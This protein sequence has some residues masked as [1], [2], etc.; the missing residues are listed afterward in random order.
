MRSWL[1]STIGLLVTLLVL[2]VCLAFFAIRMATRSHP[3]P[4]RT[5]STYTADTAAVYRNAFGI[6]HIVASTAEDAVTVQGY[7]HAQDRLWQM[8]LYRR[9]GRGRLAEIIGNEAVSVDVFMRTLG[10]AGIA[11]Q[12]L[13]QSS[14]T[15]RT[16]LQAYARGVNAYIQDQ[17]DDIAFEFDALDYSPEPWTPEDCLIVGRMIAFELSLAF[18]SDIAY[19][20]I[21]AQRTLPIAR[22]YIP[23]GR[24]GEPTVVDTTKTRPVPTAQPSPTATTP[25]SPAASAYAL[26]PQSMQAL[27]AAFRSVRQALNIQA[28]GIGSNAWA[29]SRGP[30]KGALLANDPHMS[31]GM[32]SKFYQI[33][34]ATPTL[35]VVGMSVPGMPLVVSG[36]NDGVAWGVTNVMQDDVDFFLER[37]DKNPNYYVGTNGQRTKFRFQRDTIR[38]KG[39]ADTLI[40]IRYTTRSA[41]ISDAHLFRDPSVLFTAPRERATTL[42]TTSCLTYRWTASSASDEVLTLY[43]LATARSLA[44]VQRAVTTWRAPA[45]NLTVA[46]Q[47]GQVATIPMGVAPRRVQTDPHFLNPGWDAAFDWQGTVPLTTAGTLVAQRGFAVAANNTLSATP[48]P[49]IGT[50]YE[51]S[52]R[53]ERIH[54]LLDMYV[55]YTVRDAQL[56]QQD[57]VSPYAQHLLERLLPVLQRGTARFGDVERK[58]LALLRSWDGSCATIDPAAAVYAVFQQRMIE[59]TFQDELG[60]QLF[61]DWAFVGNIPVRRLSELVDQPSHVLFDDLR[62]PQRE[63][64]TWIAIRSF[65]EAVQHVRDAMQSDNPAQWR[66]G[67]LHTVTFG[68]RFGRNPLMRPIMDHGP[69]EMSGLG[70]TINNSEWSVYAPF[71]TKV[72]AAMRIICD[73]RDTVVYSVVPGGVSGQP[74]S[75][76]YADQVQLWLRGGYVRMSA[77]RDVPGD[78]V[79]YHTFLP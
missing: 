1:Q 76:H 47:N 5:S 68:H 77:T 65:I 32:P 44:D 37:V 2:V 74:L 46:L 25:A 34:L 63:D 62:T 15:T 16:L 71:D 43:R 69:F 30:G 51:P 50:L 72:A 67:Q 14:A 79:R 54:Q 18:W 42:L 78:Y 6:P 10:I 29:V 60:Q 33:H 58:V 64:L 8:D 27:A 61:M 3:T 66:Y 22:L 73:L 45:F 48:S 59:N 24:A 40:D 19:A 55:D 38:V 20:Q 7:V 28:S 17:Q 53:A 12:Q 13:A 35:H 41:V 11:K 52:S 26:P 49:F 9:I 57:V 56:M 75:P 21:A 36:R 70:T 31:V 39:H 23:T 4:Q